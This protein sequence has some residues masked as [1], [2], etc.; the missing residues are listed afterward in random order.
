MPARHAA[1]PQESVQPQGLPPGPR[2]SPGFFSVA[3]TGL[4]PGAVGWPGLANEQSPGRVDRSRV[5]WRSPVPPKRANYCPIWSPILCRNFVEATRA[6][7]VASNRPRESYKLQNRDRD[8]EVSYPLVN[9]KL[10]IRL[11]KFSDPV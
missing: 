2:S 4:P 5:G 6:S 1:S 7:F 8:R 10:L 11:W 9:R 3:D